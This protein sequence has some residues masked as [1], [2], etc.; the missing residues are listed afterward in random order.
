M[1]KPIPV[2]AFALAA[3]AATN[4][5]QTP[6]CA[7][8]RGKIGVAE[9]K[10]PEPSYPQ[11][12]VVPIW[13][14]LLGRDAN[15]CIKVGVVGDGRGKHPDLAVASG[16]PRGDVE[17]IWLCKITETE[18]GFGGVVDKSAHV[19]IKLGRKIRFECDHVLDWTLQLGARPSREAD[20]T[21][22]EP[23]ASALR[24]S[25]PT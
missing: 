7:R 12:S 9:G 6:D 8:R 25:R 23:E 2:F 11:A 4:V 5:I 19:Q 24:E 18:R 17:E 14:T 20:E 21:L 15:I 16:A 13:R 3:Y 1:V 22:A 10:T